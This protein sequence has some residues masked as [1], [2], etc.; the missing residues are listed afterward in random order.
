[1][2]NVDEEGDEIEEILPEEPNRKRIKKMEGSECSSQQHKKAISS[3]NQKSPI[4]FDHY[5]PVHAQNST[6]EQREKVNAQN[7]SNYPK[8]ATWKMSERD[9]EIFDQFLESQLGAPIG[10]GQKKMGVEKEISAKA[11][12]R[13]LDG[14]MDA[15][16]G[17]EQSLQYF[18]QTVEARN[19]V[20]ALNKNEWADLK[21]LASTKGDLVQEWVKE[22]FP[23]LVG[24]GRMQWKIA[25]LIGE[26]LG[27]PGHICWCKVCRTPQREEGGETEIPRVILEGFNGEEWKP[28]VEPSKYVPAPKNFERISGGKRQRNKKG[29]QTSKE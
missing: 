4:M 12:R 25:V 23:Q 27:S 13:I 10:K 5:W 19:W 7:S 11:M 8:G 24:K 14:V 21:K 29:N 6:P 17:A 28:S 26:L 1:V 20:M 18:A 16:L 3:E 9:L 15:Y 2:T 22:R